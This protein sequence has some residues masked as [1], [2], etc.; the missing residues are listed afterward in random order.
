MLFRTPCAL[1]GTFGRNCDGLLA[2]RIGEPDANPMLRPLSSFSVWS[3]LQ[4]AKL[5]KKAF[6]RPLKNI[7]VQETLKAK[8]SLKS[9][10][11]PD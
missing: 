4:T 11:D 5:T 2:S 6:F 7:Y 1:D 10:L 8:D 3:L 9:L